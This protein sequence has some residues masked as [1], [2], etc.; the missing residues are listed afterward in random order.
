MALGYEVDCAHDLAEAESLLSTGCYSAVIADL[1]LSGMHSM[2]GLEV[3]KSV[4]T[5]CP[6]AK[7][8]VLTAYGSGEVETEVRKHDIS[9]FLQKPKPLP[10]IAQVLFGLVE[11]TAGQHL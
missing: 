10:E 1:R 6:E 9:A 3:I 11:S 7:I 5:Y 4:H 8:I 2:D